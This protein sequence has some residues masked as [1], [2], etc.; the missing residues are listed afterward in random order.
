MTREEILAEFESLAGSQGYYGRLLAE[1]RELEEY[2]PEAYEEF[3][4]QFVGCKD[5]L[6]VILT[7]ECG[8]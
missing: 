1:L 8:M 2:E 3:F 5:M 6:D 4:E 7:L